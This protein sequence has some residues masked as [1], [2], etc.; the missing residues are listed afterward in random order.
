MVPD[1]TKTRSHKPEFASRL[2]AFV[3]INLGLWLLATS[4]LASPPAITVPPQKRTV[5]AG[6][7]YTFAV[8]ASGSAPLNYQWRKDGSNLADKTNST[9]ALTAVQTNAAGAYSVVITNVEGAVTSA[10]VL[11]TVRLA[12]DPLY[13]TPQDGW[14]YLFA[15]DGAAGS[16][17]AALDGTWNHE[18]DA[19]S[20]DGRGVGNG[21]S[22]GVSTTNGTLTIEDTVT[23]GTGF[24]NR[25]YYFTRN[26]AQDAAVTNATTLLNDGV[27]LTFRARLTPPADPLLELTNAP[28]GLVNN[29][30]GKG[31]FGLRQAGASGL[32][33]SFSL[34]QATEDISTA[35]S[36][37]FSQAGLHMN[38]LNGNAR[39]AAVDPGEGGTTNLLALDPAQ[40]HEFWITI[41][42]NGTDPGTHR[43]T[44]YLDGSQTPTVFNV[45]AGTGNDGPA[46]NYLALGMGSSAQRGGVDIDYFG[47]KA[48]VVLPSMFNQPVGIAAQPASQFVAE[49]Q[50]A[51]YNVGVTGTPPYR[52]QWQ[53]DG[54]TIPGA[55]NSN[56]STAPVTV[57]DA[58][59]Q[60]TV[61]VSNDCNTVTSSPPALLQLLGA[62]IITA[63]P[64][65][66]TVTNGDPATFTVVV[67]SPVTPS[68]QWRFN[69]GNLANQTNAT[70]VI[71][72]AS[73]ANA[74]NYDVMVANNSGSVT[75]TLAQLT[76]ILFDYG[77]APDPAFPTLKA[78]NG[79]RHKI[80]PGIQLGAALDA[81]A[82]GQPNSS[83]TGDD[84]SGSDDEDGVTFLTPLLAGQPATLQVVAS[85]NGFLNA[86]LD[87]DRNGSWSGAGEQIFTNAPLVAGTNTI[88]LLVPGSATTGSVNGNVTSQARFRYTTLQIGRAHV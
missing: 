54:T 81:E 33:I 37:N 9:L 28:N 12:G 1:A 77:D 35:T 18:L 34:H 24:N 80:V 74:G 51:T 82:D 50:I 32:L 66:L 75:S 27:T 4:A 76:V 22:G 14:A 26:L 16:L 53:R 46:T 64:A 10:P 72:P 85:T 49:G 36:F 60:F 57:G 56:Y 39:S 45:T 29:T 58:G 5:V 40:F 42:D 47:Y 71:N 3:A 83:A 23:S 70:L 52:Y 69:G 79:A 86:W 55:T 62:P 15:G 43:V 38:N 6:T 65:N 41:A 73:S 67:T 31:M 2:R 19:W 13:P 20:G 84:L 21:L 68:Y 48:G 61:I 11:L 44:V 63:Q 25:R 59:A 7:D 88:A 30:D 78:S 8:T 17:T 87:F